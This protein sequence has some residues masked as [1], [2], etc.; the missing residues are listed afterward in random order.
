MMKAQLQSGGGGGG[1][2][3]LLHG[4]LLIRLSRGSPC[5]WTRKATTELFFCDDSPVGA[6][7]S[8]WRCEDGEVIHLASITS[9][10]RDVIMALAAAYITA[11]G[12]SVLNCG[13]CFGGADT[14]SLLINHIYSQFGRETG[15][16]TAEQTLQ[17]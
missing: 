11:V 14:T 8:I 2:G 13:G 10:C 17:C 16:I 3:V 15:T 5:R 4:H 1:R 7:P 12:E 6:R 9:V